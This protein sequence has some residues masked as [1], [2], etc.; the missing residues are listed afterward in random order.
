M[1]K[2]CSHCGEQARDESKF[3]SNCGGSN[4]TTTEDSLNSP[5]YTLN[6]ALG[7]M[8]E[9]PEKERVFLGILGAF[10][11]SL[12]GGVIYVILYQLGIL[13]AVCGWVTFTLAG[14]G[15]RKFSK[16]KER[17]SLK[18]IIVSLVMLVVVILLAEYVCIAIEIYKE[19]VNDYYITFLDAFLFVPTLLTDS[20]ALRATLGDLGF[21][22]LFGFIAVIGNI[23]N[24][25]KGRK[26]EKQGVEVGSQATPAQEENTPPT[27]E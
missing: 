21:S 16:T 5:A 18:S 2:I 9:T 13:A 8:P 19:L 7:G 1:A 23:T 12:A 6:G 22:Y 24:F 26:A 4:F 10:L 27:E 25:F 20:E 11:F 14:V 17:F 15:Y 3:C